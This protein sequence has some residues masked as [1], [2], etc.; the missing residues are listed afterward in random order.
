MALARPHLPESRQLY[1]RAPLDS[2][3]VGPLAS[4]PPSPADALAEVEAEWRQALSSKTIVGL[5]G[6]TV[7]IG[8]S[9]ANMAQIGSK[10]TAVSRQHASIVDAGNGLFELH[11]SGMNGV[12]VNGQ[13]HQAG[14]RVE[15]HSNDELNFV[16]IRFRFR[17][18]EQPDGGDEW[19]PAPVRK[20]LA[21]PASGLCVAP[22]KR[23]RLLSSDEGGLYQ[24]STDTLVGAED[25]VHQR[26]G[27][28]LIDSLPPSSPPPM[29]LLDSD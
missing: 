28:H 20:R 1:C 3:A 17:A 8:R 11:V 18:P 13:L 7:T 4:S 15:L 24:N 29:A 16:G 10:A 25:S 27:Q 22:N 26:F 2:G 5:G 14:A 6:R 9:S 12:R 21:D 19:W 23:V